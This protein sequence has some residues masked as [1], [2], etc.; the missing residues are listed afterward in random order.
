MILF[1]FVLLVQ[2]YLIFNTLHTHTPITESYSAFLDLANVVGHIKIYV[3]KRANT[4]RT[5]END[6]LPNRMFIGRSLILTEK[7]THKLYRPYFILFIFL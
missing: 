2:S 6:Y 4:S 3:T 5:A 7:W 1:L